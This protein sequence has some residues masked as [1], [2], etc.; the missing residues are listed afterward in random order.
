ML[1]PEMKSTGEVMGLDRDF[2]NAFLKSQLGAGVR[3]PQSGH[4]LHLGQGQRQGHDHAAG[5][6]A[7]RRWA[8]SIMATAGTADRLGQAVGLEVARVN[9]VYEG[10]PHIVDAM[11]SGEVQLVFNTTRGRRR[12]S[13]T[14]SAC[15]ARR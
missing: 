1:G 4:G 9:K 13:P 8:F 6:G 5:Q 10:R 12:P 2:A 14:A 11:K 3:L 7:D 15:G